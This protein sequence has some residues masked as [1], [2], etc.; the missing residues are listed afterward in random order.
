EKPI[1]A[2]KG[3][4]ATL[5]QRLALPANSRG[6]S[7]PMTRP[8]TVIATPKA[9]SATPLRCPGLSIAGMARPL[10]RPTRAKSRAQ[11]ASE[12]EIWEVIPRYSRFEARRRYAEPV[13]GRQV[14]PE[15]REFDPGGSVWDLRTAFP[16]GDFRPGTQF[17][18]Q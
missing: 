18:H 2:P 11:R 9:S 16:M 12:E 14:A 13:E 5:G 7:A 6:D 17:G 4:K 8:E 10:S 1:R 15:T 3:M